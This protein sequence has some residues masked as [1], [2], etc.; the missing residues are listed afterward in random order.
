MWWSNRQQNKCCLCWLL[1]NWLE[2]NSWDFDQVSL[3]FYLFHTPK[4]TGLEVGWYGDLEFTCQPVNLLF[5][6]YLLLMYFLPP[7]R[8]EGCW[9]P[10]CSLLCSG[11][12]KTNASSKTSLW[13]VIGVTVIKSNEIRPQ[14]YRLHVHQIPAPTNEWM[15]GSLLKS[16]YSY[17]V[18]NP[19]SKF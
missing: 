12:N 5:P 10:L 13:S 11:R 15:N 16:I 3:S 7:P 1:W 14:I 17:S 6:P 9:R 18:P 4:Q 8:E 2:V 19:I